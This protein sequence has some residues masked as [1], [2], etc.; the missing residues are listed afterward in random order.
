MKKVLYIAYFFPPVSGAGVQRSLKFSKYLQLYG[1][2]PVI[3]TVKNSTYPLEDMSLLNDCMDNM[4]I[5]RVNSPLESFF[6]DGKAPKYLRPLL[7]YPDR[8][9]G[10]ALQ[11][12]L[13]ARKYIK[14]VDAIITTSSPVSSHLAGYLLKTL[15]GVPWVA[16]FRDPWTMNPFYKPYTRVHNWLDKKLEKAIIRKADFLIITTFDKEH[17]FVERPPDGKCLSI[18][19]GY[20][21]QDFVNINISKQKKGVFTIGYNGGLYDDVVTETFFA[22]FRQFIN[23]YHLTPEQVKLSI[24]GYLR[25]PQVQEKWK[26]INEYIEFHGFIEHKASIQALYQS[27][28]LL[29]LTR[30][31]PHNPDYDNCIPG[32][33][34]EYLRSGQPILHVAQKEC[35]V[36]NIIREF[37]QGVNAFQIE[38]VIE[39]LKKLYTDW[40]ADQLINRVDPRILSF[41]RRELTKQLADI[42]DRVMAYQHLGE[43]KATGEQV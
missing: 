16:D 27:D 15:Y 24:Y 35:F 2:H 21:E 23:N 41:E 7:N 40:K 39:A 18:P 29:L 3:V 32:K 12:F 5:V 43:R 28:V 13:K 11:A 8:H 4:E 19:N 38:D 25:D 33:T 22:G 10:F 42:L 1:W 30:V 31:G 37:E 9:W 36:S 17:H 6:R 14:S 20:D 26:D 34:F